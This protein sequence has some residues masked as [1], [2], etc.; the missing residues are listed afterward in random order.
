MVLIDAV[1]INDGGGKVLLDY[2]ISE[3]EKTKLRIYYLLDS[4][5][6]DNIPKVKDENIVHFIKA[7]FITRYLFYK[8][9]NKK[10]STVLCFGNLPPYVKIH[11]KVYTYF[12]QQMFIKI[13]AEIN[14]QIKSLLRIKQVILNSVKENT[15]AWI[16]Q[17]PLLKE[18]LASK[19]KI[20]TTNILI[21]PFYPPFQEKKKDGSFVKR[22]QN[23]YIYV[24]DATPN[25]NHK[26]L[27]NAFCSFYD[28]Y[29]VGTLALTVSKRFLEITSL[30]ESRKADGYPIEN[31][32]FI[33]RNSLS[34]IYQSKE[35]LVFPSLSESYGLGIVEAIENGC[36]VIGA[37]L[38]YLYAVCKPSLSFDPQD[39]ESIKS[40]F[41]NSIGEVKP[42]ISLTSN[43]IKEIIQI[44]N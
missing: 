7:S 4:R 11:C 35:F 16:V 5:I 21:I 39:Q 41:G 36:K 2:L 44:L 19:Y 34:R 3:I 42:S 10:F 38:P 13:P 33:E 17:S 22:V 18:Q 43:K 1:H 15:D 8:S 6:E 24:S 14:V 23:S 30:I 12:H 28:Q 40:A 27:I 20:D 29:K 37:D 31:L 26:R 32:G 25:K 9:N